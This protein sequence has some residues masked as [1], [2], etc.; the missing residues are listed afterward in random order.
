MCLKKYRNLIETNIKSGNTLYT[1]HMPS[2]YAESLSSK[3]QL[4]EWRIAE[5][6]DL[7]SIVQTLHQAGSLMALADPLSRLCSPSGG[8]YDMTLPVKLATLLQHLPKWVKNARNVRVHTNKDT[9]AARRIVQK[10]R[11]PMNPISPSQLNS[12]TK[13]DFIIGTPYADRGTLKISQLLK[14]DRAFACLHPTSLINEIP[15]ENTGINTIIVGKLKK[16]RK[17]VLTDYN[18]T[19]IINLPH[20]SDNDN[21]DLDHMIYMVEPVFEHGRL[22]RKIVK[23]YP[24]ILE[25]ATHV[26]KRDLGCNGQ[27]AHTTIDASLRAPHRATTSLPETNHQRQELLL[28]LRS[29]LTTGIPQGP[30]PEETPPPQPAP[31]PTNPPAQT[32][33]RTFHT[34]RSGRQVVTTSLSPANES[35]HTYIPPKLFRTQNPTIVPPLARWT[36]HQMRNIEIAADKLQFVKTGIKGYPTLL[37]NLCLPKAKPKIIVPERIQESLIKATHEEI[38]HLGYSKVR[39]ILKDLYYWPKMED[40]IEQVVRDCVKCIQSTVRRQHLSSHFNARS[41]TK[42]HFPRHSYGIDFCRIYKGEILSAADLYTREVTFWWLQDCDQQHVANALIN[43]LI[44]MR[45][46]PICL[47]SDNAPELMQGIVRDINSY[48]KID[49]ITTGGHNP[50]DSAIFERNNQMIGAMLQKCTDAQYKNV[51]DYLPNMAFAINTTNSSTLNCIPFEAGHG[52][53]VRTVVA[54][55]RAD[56]ARIQ[57]DTEGGTGD[58]TLEDI[59]THFDKSLPKAMLE[60]SVRLSDAVNAQSE[61]HRRMTSEKLNMSGRKIDTSLLK[62]KSKLYFYK[63]PSQQ[64]TINLNRMAKHCQH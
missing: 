47:R 59:S 23:T 9:A 54:S 41:K 16:T 2:L 30:K 64:I 7:N 20:C 18:L 56:S 8:L 29:G 38:L 36:S 37:K 31:R 17:T 3:G 42:M 49:Q 51:K 35:F 55:A 61:W 26:A 48:L 40:K 62:L 34:L 4:S 1:D 13:S 28:G 46:V 19:W 44:F 5:V 21:E 57:F 39:H 63:P 43:G 25:N 33:D 58:N 60:F 12:A 53:P 15:R 22:L 24:E 32:E 14:E 27:E 45:G 50:R 52:L 10:W 11:T 6:A